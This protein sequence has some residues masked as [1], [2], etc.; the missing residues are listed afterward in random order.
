MNTIKNVQHNHGADECPATKAERKRIISLIII[1]V[2]FL[3]MLV[4]N[5][6]LA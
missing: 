5:E 2:I 6:L 4:A 1:A 3:V